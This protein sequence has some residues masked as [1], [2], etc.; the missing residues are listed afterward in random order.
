MP[1]KFTKK[2]DS[3]YVAFPANSRA[4]VHDEDLMEDLS[5]NGLVIGGTG[6][7]ISVEEVPLALRHA[8]RLVCRFR[9]DKIIFAILK[10]PAD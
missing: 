9:P 6:K 7:S 4:E 3:G 5:W 2:R 8:V 10:K 1:T